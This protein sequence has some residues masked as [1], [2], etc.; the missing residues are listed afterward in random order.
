M[1]RSQDQ[2]SITEQHTSTM[3]ADCEV[4]LESASTHTNIQS[5]Q[6][7]PSR[8]VSVS[9]TAAPNESSL[10]VS[11]IRDQLTS[12]GNGQCLSYL[13]EQMEKLFN[14]LCINLPVDFNELD[15]HG[16]AVE[17]SE[18]RPLKRRADA[19]DEG[20]NAEADRRARKRGRL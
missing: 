12:N 19:D 5:I 20:E 2:P 15:K 10:E 6:P 9:T 14:Q 3:M 17:R 13:H 4:D 8:R 7:A 18:E 1:D 16:E 11:S